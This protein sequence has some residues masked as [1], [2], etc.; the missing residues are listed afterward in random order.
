MEQAMSLIKT[1]TDELQEELM[2]VVQERD[3]ALNQLEQVKDMLEQDT[4]PGPAI[5]LALRA[6]EPDPDEDG[7]EPTPEIKLVNRCREYGHVGALIEELTARKS[8]L[9]DEIDELEQ[10]IA[11]REDEPELELEDEDEE[12]EATS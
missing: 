4:N 2:Q 9:A 6:M 5:R 12:E 3:R 11:E 1:N 8:W 10:R 7:F